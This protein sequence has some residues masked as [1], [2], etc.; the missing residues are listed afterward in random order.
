MGSRY[1]YTP[2]RFELSLLLSLALLE[3]DVPVITKLIV[4]G[5]FQVISPSVSYVRPNFLLPATAPLGVWNTVITLIP[6][7]LGEGITVGVATIIILD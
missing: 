2:S 5:H 4:T 3:T 7:H 6:N 1:T